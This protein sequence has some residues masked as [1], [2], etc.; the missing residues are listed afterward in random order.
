[1][2][3]LV[4]S[5]DLFE[6]AVVRLR[7]GRF[8]EVTRYDVDPVAYARALRGKVARLHVVDLEGSRSGAATQ[9]EA[10]GAITAAF[11]AGVQVG[12][13]VRVLEDVERL[14]DVGVERFVLGTTAIEAPDT[15]AQIALKFPSRVVLAVDARDGL[16]AVRGWTSTSAATPIDVAM[17]FSSLPLDALLFTDVARDGTRE[18]PAIDATVRLAVE[19]GRRVI[20]SG[21][22]GALDHLRAL[23][24]CDDLFGVVVGRALFDG[25]FTADEAIAALASR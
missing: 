15:L 8:D 16:V 11:G 14:A 1:M 12:G 17:R 23:A 13:G 10:I 19:S 24:A 4:P 6:G 9:L 25:R 22:V 2:V 5:I 7:Q 21:G 20:A 3:Q 18:G